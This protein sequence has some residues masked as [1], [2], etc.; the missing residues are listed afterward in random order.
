MTDP[1]VRA[2]QRDI[3]ATGWAEDGLVYVG[4]F[5]S[6]MDK[7]RLIRKYGQTHGD[8]HAHHMTVWFHSD[9]EADKPDFSRL[10]W[11]KDVALKVVGY[12]EDDK[13]QAVVVQPPTILR[14]AGRIPHITI[15][16]APGVTPLYSNEL[17][18]RRHGEPVR[19]A[20][21][22]KGKVGWYGADGRVYLT[23]PM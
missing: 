16:T 6:N 4:V 8:L 21:S 12:V 11:G 19:G 5:L 20:P 1:L 10:P 2:W 23:A 7:L 3:L 18:R 15:S 13:A 9:G 17:A 14:P 22:I